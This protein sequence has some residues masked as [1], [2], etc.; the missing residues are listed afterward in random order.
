[1][2]KLASNVFGGRTAGA[3]SGGGLRTPRCGQREFRRYSEESGSADGDIVWW[4]YLPR[5]SWN[6]DVEMAAG[7]PICIKGGEN[8]M[9]S[10]KT[11]GAAIL[12][13]SKIDAIVGETMPLPL[14][15][16]SSNA[17]AEV[18]ENARGAP[19]HEY[20]AVCIINPVDKLEWIGSGGVSFNPT[21]CRLMPTQGEID[22]WEIGDDSTRIPDANI[23]HFF[24]NGWEPVVS[25]SGRTR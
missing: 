11:I 7:D 10:E 18:C 19:R 8:P 13:L 21:I 20:S 22:Q 15:F 14:I 5:V 23:A 12:L 4:R 16:S 1:M 17:K 6:F 24:W 25:H 3:D 9:V 2:F